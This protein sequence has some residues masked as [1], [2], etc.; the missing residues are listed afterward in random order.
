MGVFEGDQISREK[1]RSDYLWCLHCERTYKRGKFRKV[2]DLQMCPYEGC[3][4]DT[5]L[6][7]ID[8]ENIRYHHPEYPQIPEEDKV[9]PEYA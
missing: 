3:D 7:A 4:G 6:D 2:G 1:K 8:W 5:V 9:Y